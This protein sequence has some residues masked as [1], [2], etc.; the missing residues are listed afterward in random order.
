MYNDLTFLWYRI[1]T[2]RRKMTSCGNSSTSFH[3]KSFTYITEIII[4]LRG[5]AKFF[6]FLLQPHVGRT[7]MSHENRWGGKKGMKTSQF[8][9]Y[10]IRNF[11]FL[12]HQLD[13]LFTIH[14]FYEPNYGGLNQTENSILY[15]IFKLCYLML[16]NC[17]VLL[18]SKIPNHKTDMQTSRY[19]CGAKR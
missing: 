5:E 9:S 12:S 6:L 16:S 15:L 7:D 11:S 2:I 14:S 10:L 3:T 8:A 18:F 4:F 1:K 17:F 13:P 19:N